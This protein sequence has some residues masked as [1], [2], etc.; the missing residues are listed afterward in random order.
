MR[1]QS[2]RPFGRHQARRQE[3]NDKAAGLRRV[4][5]ARDGRRLIRKQAGMPMTD[6]VAMPQR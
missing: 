2:A 1:N 6:T 3:Y 5:I 4:S